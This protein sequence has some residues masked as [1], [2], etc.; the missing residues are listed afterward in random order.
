MAITA[1]LAGKI[2]TPSDEIKN[3][4]ILVESDRITDVGK[5]ESVKIPPGSTVFDHNDRI[6]TPGFIDMHIHGAAGHDFMEATPEAL[7]TIGAFLARHG[8]TSYVA[9]TV[10]AGIERT[11]EAATGL[12]QIINA[13]RS[14]DSTLK[15]AVAQPLGVHFEGPFINTIRRGAHPAADILKP[16]IETLTRLVDAT[17]GTTLVLALAPELENALLLLEYA[18]ERGVRVGIGHSNANFEEAEAAI[19]AGATHAVHLYNAMRPFSHRDPGIMGAVLTD[20]RVSAEL[21]CDGMH[22]DPAAV[23]LVA[24]AKGLARVVLITDSLSAAGMPDGTYNLG[25]FA[26]NV[27]GGICRTAE[28][29]LA[30]SS[31]T[32]EK[33]LRNLMTFTGSTFRD[34]LPCATSNPAKLLGFEERKGVI[35]PGADADL[36][37]LDANYVVRQAYVRGQPAIATA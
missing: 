2:L 33:A 19:A 35:A 18:R 15:P 31:I 4:V 28:G 25:Q 16:S 24:R 12:G 17:G 8:T 3:G 30:G 23:R 20:N 13:A 14:P 5:A 9:T 1:I 22:V 26:V 36:A 7:S 6:V 34:C 29:N 27:V 37:V 21:I 11:I 10:T 32:L